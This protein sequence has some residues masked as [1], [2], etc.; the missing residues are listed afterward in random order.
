M[1]SSHWKKKCHLKQERI[2]LLY[3]CTMTLQHYL[4]V[5]IY[6]KGFTIITRHSKKLKLRKYYEIFFYYLLLPSYKRDKKDFFGN[7]DL[8][9]R[10]CEFFFQSSIK[11]KYMNDMRTAIFLDVL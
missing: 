11:N 10:D 4:N 8:V 1:N 6:F 9:Q 2:C 7:S 3:L 5:Y